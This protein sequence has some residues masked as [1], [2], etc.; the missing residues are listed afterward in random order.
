MLVIVRAN[1]TFM[2]VASEENNII[3]CLINN[4]DR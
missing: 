4:D 2:A 3:Y 1:Q